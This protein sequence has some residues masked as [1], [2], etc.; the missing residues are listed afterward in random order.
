MVSVE[1]KADKIL[2]GRFNEDTNPIEA[3]E[4]IN[5]ILFRYE[6]T[7]EAVKKIC[8]IMIKKLKK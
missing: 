6:A 2:E 3:F 7:N 5:H 4:I 1:E 8:R